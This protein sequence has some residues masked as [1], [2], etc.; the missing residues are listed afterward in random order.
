M[1]PA[2][3]ANLRQHRCVLCS[4]GSGSGTSILPH[5]AAVV[6]GQARHPG[7][8]G[9]GTRHTWQWGVEGHVCSPPIWGPTLLAGAQQGVTRGSHSTP[10][11]AAQPC[12]RSRQRG[13]GSTSARVTINLIS[14]NPS[15]GSRITPVTTRLTRRLHLHCVSAADLQIN[16]TAGGTVSVLAPAGSQGVAPPSCPPLPCGCGRCWGQAGDDTVTLA[17]PCPVG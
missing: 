6:R 2:L 1:L 11:Q 5:P 4:A 7:M 9:Q 3:S 12:K 17:M 14:V 10:R 16:A 15:V 13:A 8:G